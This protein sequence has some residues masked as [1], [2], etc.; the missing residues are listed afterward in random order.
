MQK[1]SPSSPDL[2]VHLSCRAPPGSVPGVLRSVSTVLAETLTLAFICA[3]RL[4]LY[5]VNLYA[6]GP[7]LAFTRTSTTACTEFCL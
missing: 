6:Q 7:P 5:Q 3:G 2:A 4:F 1:E